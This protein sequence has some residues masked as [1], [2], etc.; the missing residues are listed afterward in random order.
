MMFCECLYW[1][2][3]PTDN[4][5][6]YAC[7]SRNVLVWMV[8][9]M[10]AAW[11]VVSQCNVLLLMVFL[12]CVMAVALYVHAWLIHCETVKYRLCKTSLFPKVTASLRSFV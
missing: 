8:Y 6:D 2:T 9:G 5:I 4:H 12:L 7:I 10:Y 1:R 11:R 3:V